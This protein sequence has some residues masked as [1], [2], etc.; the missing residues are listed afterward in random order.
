MKVEIEKDRSQE[1]TVK[2]SNCGKPD[3]SDTANYCINCG[4]QLKVLGEINPSAKYRDS[5]PQQSQ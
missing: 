1:K 4:N 5:D 3:C 2:C